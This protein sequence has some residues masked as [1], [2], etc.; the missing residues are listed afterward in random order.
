METISFDVKESED[1][2]RGPSL[3]VPETD[4]LLYSSSFHLCLSNIHLCSSIVQSFSSSVQLCSREVQ[5]CWSHVQSWSWCFVCHPRCSHYLK[6]RAS[7]LE[8]GTSE[9]A[10]EAVQAHSSWCITLDFEWDYGRPPE[11]PPSVECTNSCVLHPNVCNNEQRVECSQRQMALLVV[12][13]H[14]NHHAEWFFDG[15][16]IK[17]VHHMDWFLEAWPTLCELGASRKKSSEETWQFFLESSKNSKA[18]AFVVSKAQCIVEGAH[19]W[20][21]QIQTTCFLCPCTALQWIVLDWHVQTFLAGGS[22]KVLFELI[23][24]RR[25]IS[26]ARRCA[27]SRIPSSTRR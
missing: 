14:R 27:P 25:G 19:G 1:H 8:E 2:E 24:Q 17:V 16:Q 18:P 26:K 3:G 12:F 9:R 7:A 22:V 11:T 10:G 5:S 20:W 13:I 21:D 6:G 4:V 15:N 23:W